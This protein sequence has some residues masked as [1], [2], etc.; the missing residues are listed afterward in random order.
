[1][2]VFTPVDGTPDR[3]WIEPRLGDWSTMHSV[4]PRGYPA[5]VRVFHPVAA[6]LLEWTGTEHHVLEERTLTW[7][8][9][10]GLTGAVAHPL[11]QWDRIRRGLAEFGAATRGWDYG[12]PEQGRMPVD[13]LARLAAVLSQSGETSVRAGLWE[14]NGALYPGSSS[15]VMLSAADTEDETAED[16]TT[17]D[18]TAEQASEVDMDIPFSPAEWE[19]RKLELPHRAYFVFD[20]DLRRLSEPAWVEASGWGAIASFW[21]NTPNLLWPVDRSWFLVSEIDFDSTVIGCSA[22]VAAV[23]MADPL[24][25]TGMLAEGASLSF[26]ADPINS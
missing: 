10:A 2:A 14:G 18:E 17:E 22:E 9:V 11:M 13:L 8:E 6:R 26:D 24:L 12:K 1:M 3:E 5:Y 21:G 7:S 25:E 20:A 23:L 19:N 15:V 4:V 16:E